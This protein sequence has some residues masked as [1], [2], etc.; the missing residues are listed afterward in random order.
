MNTEYKNPLSITSQFSFC[1]LPFRLDTYSGC[2]FNCI[3]CYSHKRGGNSNFSNI[4]IAN[5]DSIIRK[6]ENA[7]T[8]PLITTGLIS[9]YIRRRMPVHF[10]GMSDPFQKVEKKW[11][12]SL[13]VLKYLCSINYPIVISTKSILLSSSQYL[14][15]LKTNRNILVQYSFSTLNYQES[16]ILEPNCKSPK[17]RLESLEILSSNGINT[18]IRWQPYIVGISESPIDF[19]KQIKY[20]GVSHLTIEFLKIPIDNKNEWEKSLKPLISLKRLYSEGRSNTIGREQSLMPHYKLEIIQQ[21]KKEL[22]SNNIT[23]GIG[24]NELHHYSDTQC[25]CGVDKYDGFNNW[26]KAQFS[27]ALKKSTDK[28]IRFDNIKNEWMPQGAIDKHLNSKSRIKTNNRHNSVIDYLEYR[29]NK[30]ESDF[31]PS[32]YFGVKYSGQKDENGFCIFELENF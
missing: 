8:K 11:S 6:F 30:I 15:I 14:D 21:L 26:N 9:E 2:S 17:E 12:V 29:W 25:C 28:N 32:Q 31:N 5:P 19:V 20:I 16:K 10:G 23:L 4:K 27:F 18:A 24:D 3:Y 7:L 13:E 1:G 22:N